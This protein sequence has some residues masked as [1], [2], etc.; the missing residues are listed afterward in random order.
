MGCDTD[1]VQEITAQQE[2]RE[3]LVSSP[4]LLNQPLSLTLAN[5]SVGS[6]PVLRFEVTDGKKRPG[7]DAG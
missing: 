6:T 1:I 4:A 5:V 2:I 7:T 3:G